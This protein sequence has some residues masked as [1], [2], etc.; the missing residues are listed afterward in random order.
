[1]YAAMEIIYVVSFF[2]A[3]IYL[4]ID[5]LI[6]ILGTARSILKYLCKVQAL[7]LNLL[8]I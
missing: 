7:V 5:G 2:Q 8:V 3:L 1:M 6:N 4:T